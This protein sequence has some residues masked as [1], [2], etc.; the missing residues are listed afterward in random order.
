[1]TPFKQIRAFIVRCSPR[2]S[3]AQQKLRVEAAAEQ[4]LSSRDL[5]MQ[6]SPPLE[7]A[8]ASFSEWTEEGE[9]SWNGEPPELQYSSSPIK[10][11]THRPA[12][13][14]SNRGLSPTPKGRGVCRQQVLDSAHLTAL[15]HQLAAYLEKAESDLSRKHIV[16]AAMEDDLNALW[17]KAIKHQSKHLELEQENAR[18][19]EV[20]GLLT[21]SKWRPMRELKRRLLHAESR[22]TIAE[23]QVA[24]MKEVLAAQVKERTELHKEAY[25]LWDAILMTGEQ[26]GALD[27][28]DRAMDRL[29][30]RFDFE[31][32]HI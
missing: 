15:N 25:E 13:A 22:A 28:A 4:R 19:T 8:S 6:L 7:Q 26:A 2:T 27:R 24:R 10:Y 31:E 18:L 20:V 30:I 9:S 5:D 21:T 32:G 17:E 11:D 23:S 29:S 14:P 3:R 1:M 12:T 16:I